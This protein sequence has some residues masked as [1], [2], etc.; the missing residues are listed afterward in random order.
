MPEFSSR[1]VRRG[2]VEV[3]VEVEVEGGN[4]CDRGTVMCACLSV[5][6]FGGQVVRACVACVLLYFSCILR[7]VHCDTVTARAV[8]HSGEVMPNLYE[9]SHMRNFNWNV[10]LIR[11][12][13]KYYD[14][15]S[16]K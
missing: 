10:L 12:S 16:L 14:I 15:I 7:V 13:R 2:K 6:L 5:C 1:E 9:V 8:G 4:E 3:E 11:F